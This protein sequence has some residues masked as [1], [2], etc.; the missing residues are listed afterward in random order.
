[1]SIGQLLSVTEVKSWLQLQVNI[2]SLLVAFIRLTLKDTTQSKKRDSLLNAQKLYKNIN[3]LSAA[4][5][6][7]LTLGILLKEIV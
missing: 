3:W 1:M 5:S 6:E 4:I 7:R 2:I